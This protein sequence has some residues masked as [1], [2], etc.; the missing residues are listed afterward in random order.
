MKTDHKLLNKSERLTESGIGLLRVAAGFFF[1]IPGLFKIF[2]PED[3]RVILGDLPALLQP[4]V[5]WLFHLVSSA[6]ILGGLLLIVGWNVRIA[7][8]PLIIITVVAESLVVVHDVDS[9]MRLLSLVIHLMGVG[10]YLGIM[11]LGGGRPAVGD[12]FNLIKKVADEKGRT[13]TLAAWLLSGSGRN[14]GIAVVR[15]SIA[16]PF[17]AAFF[18]G[19]G[20]TDYTHLLGGNGWIRNPILLLS[21]LGGVAILAGFQTRSVGLLLAAL[22][23]V[24]F[25]TAGLGDYE[26][27]KIGLINLL[28]HGLILTAVT[29][30][31]RITFGSELAVEHILSKDKRNVVIVGAGFAGTQA[32][33]RLEKQLPTEWQVVLISEENYTTFNPMLAEVVGASVLPSHVIAPVRRMLKRSRFIS[34]RVTGV[35]ADKN[36]VYFSAEDKPGSIAYEH[37]VLA[38]G[39]RARMDLIPGMQEHSLPFKLLGD[40]LL[41]RN[42]VIEQMEKAELESDVERRRWLGNFIVIGGGF[43]GIELG[44]AM[45]DFIRASQRHYPNLN[46]S[47]LT[48]NIVHRGEIPLPELSEASGRHTLH[49]MSQ[50]GV[51]M[52]M[53]AGVVS[54]DA[55][56]IDLNDGGRIEGATIVSTIGTKPNSLVEALAVPNDR[57]RLLIESDM[58]AQGSNSIWAIGDC[59]LVPNASSNSLSPPTAQF[60]IREGRQVADN[61]ARAIR[62]EGLQPFTY[63]SRGSMATIGHL[64]GVAEVGTKFRL[65]GLSGWLAWRAFYLMLMPTFAKKTRIFFEWTWSMLFSPDIMNLRF[66]TTPDI[67][68]PPEQDALSAN[69]GTSASQG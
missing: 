49:R 1:L 50:R 21:L 20:N 4:H 7:V 57:G 13:A 45:L 8:I 47:D 31:R 33:R 63:E 27:S 10:L 17:I 62:G 39:S 61:I 37:L 65:A 35:D 60:A 24:H 32:A 22:V 12:R 48:V 54:V 36:K 67:D 15:F 29:A 68:R 46:D 55:N 18:I 66:T 56:G 59:A 3:F 52:V 69:Q 25:F 41:L 43:S 26:D 2:S 14:F 19:I 51:N 9:R 30:L 34:A 40:A 6:E 28:F 58:R 42:R 5:P 38:F 23:V 64:N 53:S 11:F 44:G 16:L